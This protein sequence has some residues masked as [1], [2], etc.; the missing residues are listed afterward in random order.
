M[1]IT[2]IILTPATNTIISLSNNGPRCKSQI[3]WNNVYHQ[4]K[5]NYRLKTRFLNDFANSFSLEFFPEWRESMEND[6]MFVV[7]KFRL[8]NIEQTESTDICSLLYSW[9]WRFETAE[10]PSGSCSGSYSAYQGKVA[11]PQMAM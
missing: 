7:E 4:N 1:K 2:H 3:Y 5:R 9:S 6:E 8:I 10:A 11:R